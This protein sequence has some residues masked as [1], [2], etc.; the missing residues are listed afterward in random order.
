MSPERFVAFIK[1]CHTK[2]QNVLKKS[3]KKSV[4]L[5]FLTLKF[6]L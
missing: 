6:P 5:L 3:L 2:T 4:W 1:L